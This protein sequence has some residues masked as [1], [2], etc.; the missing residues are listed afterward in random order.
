MQC[1]SDFLGGQCVINFAKIGKF[2]SQF[3][4][5][6]L[7]GNHNQLRSAWIDFWGVEKVDL[8]EHLNSKLTDLKNSAKNAAFAKS[9]FAHTPYVV[10][11]APKNE[12]LIDTC[13]KRCLK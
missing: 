2:Y 6:I 10:Q 3:G 7:S 9:T 12:V 5:S 1:F 4:S 11:M 13:R 8:V